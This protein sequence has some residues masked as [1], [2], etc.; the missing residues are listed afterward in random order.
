[1]RLDH[2]Q[3]ERGGNAGIQVDNIISKLP[4]LIPRSLQTSYHHEH[5]WRLVLGSQ[6][7]GD[8]I[9]IQILNRLQGMLGGIVGI[10]TVFNARYR[11]RAHKK[12]GGFEPA[13]AG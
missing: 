10:P 6:R 9:L 13:T 3:C 8:S 7:S 11:P 2:L 4:V 1:M 12:P 5:H